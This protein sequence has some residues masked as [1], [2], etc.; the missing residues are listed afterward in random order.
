MSTLFFI[1]HAQGSF[2]K[3]NYDKLSETGK[4]QALILA[5]YFHSIK[6][7]FDEIYSGTMERHKDTVNEYISLSKVRDIPAEEVKYDS[8]LNEYD[9]EKILT[10]LIPALLKEKPHMKEHY[11]KL[12][13]DKR[14]FQL[15]FSEV[16]NMWASGNYDMTGTAT[17]EEFTS[18]IYSFADER[19]SEHNG[20]RN[21]AVF[22]S[23]GPLSALIMKVLSLSLNTSMLIRDRIVNSSITRFRYTAYKIMISSF[24]E[25]SHLELA[26]G[27]DIITYR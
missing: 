11:E 26:G 15:V 7:H 17:W 1:R 18:G 10:I 25:Y 23:G 9:A 27:K 19:M 24:N 20:D 2:G 13:S 21:I 22:T 3:G 4:K 6:I 8:R 5:E 12:L 14:S 16:M